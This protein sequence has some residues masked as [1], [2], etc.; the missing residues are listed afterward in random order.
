MDEK[1]WY[2]KK[3]ESNTEGWKAKEGLYDF[4]LLRPRVVAR[5]YTFRGAYDWEDTKYAIDRVINPIYAAVRIRDYDKCFHD[6]QNQL[7]VR[8]YG[9]TTEFDKFTQENQEIRKADL[10]SYIYEQNGVLK[11]WFIVDLHVFRKE[12]AQRRKERSIEDVCRISVTGRST[13]EIKEKFLSFYLR[14]FRDTNI[15]VDSSYDIWQDQPKI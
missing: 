14:K 12:V 13:E 3:V 1:D 9:K 11:E 4:L 7:T 6:F 8:Y 5:F 15:L 10:L 2:Y